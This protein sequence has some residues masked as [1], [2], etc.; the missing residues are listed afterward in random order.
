MFIR[1]KKMP[2]GSTKVQVVKS[3]RTGTK[4]RQR[5]LRHIGTARNDHERDVFDGLARSY[6]NELLMETTGHNTLF[7]FN[8][9]TDLI[10]KSRHAQDHPVPAHVKL[11]ACR[12][13]GRA[14][15]GIRDVFGTLYQRMGWENVVGHSR[16][17]SNRTIKEMV[18]ARITQPRSKRATVRDLSDQSAVALNLDTV[19]RSMDYLD[20]DRI[21]TIRD[22]SMTLAQTL[23]PGPITALFYDTTTLSFASDTEDHLR[24]KGFSKDGKHHRV[25]VLLALLV[26]AE[27]LPVGYEVFPGNQSEG[28]TLMV[29]LEGLKE[30]YPDVALTV[31]ADAGMITKANEEALRERQI[32]YILGARI[33]NLPAALTQLV[34]DRSEYHP[35]GRTEGSETNNGY[36][37]I[38]D[39]EVPGR[40]LMTTYS[41][42]RARKDVHDRERGLAKVLKRL[43]ASKQPASL[44]SGGMAK[45]L[46]FPL[47]QATLD[48]AKIAK[49]ARWDGLRGIVA[50]GC[51]DRDP[52]DIIMQ[53]RQLAVIEACFRVNKSDLRIRPIFHWKEHRIKAHLAIC[54]MAFCCV[55]HLRYFL[56]ARGHTMSTARVQRALYGIQISILYDTEGK[57]R[58][59]MPSQVSSDARKIYQT[60]GLV[61]NR[62]PFA[63]TS[64][65]QSGPRKDGRRSSGGV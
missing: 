30:R 44:V 7:N 4:V 17:G 61:W 16:P 52:R 22:R 31:V 54:Y 10:D 63:I 29:A 45:Y 3:V 32:P 41:A 24:K 11:Q 58:Y 57:G 28:Q 62:C 38:D 13:E 50:W 60:L 34:L 56:K 36:R 23:L 2:H 48:E 18:M 47:G 59:G 37:C 19:Y 65:R 27:G 12:E 55:Q 5:V 8:E 46:S 35:W 6:M 53:Y 25:Q 21:A 15:V 40:Q 42:K 20:D 51:Q 9:Y 39:T 1:H 14:I 64:G 49:V 43:N 26:T 33:K